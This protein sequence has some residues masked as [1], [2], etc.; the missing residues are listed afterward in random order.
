MTPTKVGE[1]GIH[2]LLQIGKEAGWM[3][4]APGTRDMAAGRANAQRLQ[5]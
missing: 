5:K 2:I 3:Q 4:T 1:R